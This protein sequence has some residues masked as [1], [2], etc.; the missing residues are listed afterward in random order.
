MIHSERW[1]KF[2]STY[3]DFR[4]YF[5][6]SYII[7]THIGWELELLYFYDRGKNYS[8]NL[9]IRD[10]I[11]VT[12][13]YCNFTHLSLDPDRGDTSRNHIRL[14]ETISISVLAIKQGWENTDSSLWMTKLRKN[15]ILMES[16]YHL[17]YIPSLKKQNYLLLKI[18]LLQ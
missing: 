5:K 6:S 13:L 3:L 2:V 7:C 10:D 12:V 17:D 9:E 4:N 11:K 15:T 16:S 1:Q 18:N 14:T 8:R